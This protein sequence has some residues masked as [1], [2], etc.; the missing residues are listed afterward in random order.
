MAIASFTDILFM[1]AV[2]IFFLGLCTF[3]IGII[4]LVSRVTG[5][6][7]RSIAAQTSKLA[8]KGITEDVPGLVGN[9]SAL[10]N[11]LHQLVKTTAGIGLFL[12]VLGLGMIA[13][14][15]WMFMQYFQFI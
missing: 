15:Y 11:A 4:V 13:V 3:V 10:M 5:R 8:Q 2:T 7:T 12:I 14:S 9:A 6:H 1:M